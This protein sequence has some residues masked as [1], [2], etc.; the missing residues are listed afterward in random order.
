[1]ALEAFQA[2]RM[3]S[4]KAKLKEELSNKSLEISIRVISSE[5]S[6]GIGISDRYRGGDTIVAS[7]DEVGQV[8]IRIP[9]DRDSSIFRPNYETT[10]MVSI[11]DWN[12]VRK[13]LVLEAI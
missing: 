4:E 12:A 5:R 1:M 9:N 6:F 8:E 2:S 10:L 13:R 11:A 3:L 7:N